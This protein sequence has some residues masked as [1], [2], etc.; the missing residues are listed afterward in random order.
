MKEFCECLLLTEQIET[1]S[2]IN[3]AEVKNV[4]KKIRT[5]CNLW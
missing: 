2:A 4:W 3:I 1:N 5:L